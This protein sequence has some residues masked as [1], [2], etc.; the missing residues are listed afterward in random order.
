MLIVAER[1]FVW[2]SVFFTLQMKIFLI[3]SASSLSLMLHVIA[4]SVKAPQ[5]CSYDSQSFCLRFSS[6][7][8]SNVVLGGLLN[9]VSSNVQNS[10]NE[11]AKIFTRGFL[12]AKT[13][14]PLLPS[15]E[16]KI[17]LSFCRL[18]LVSSHWIFSFLRW[19]AFTR[20][21]RI[22]S[23]RSCSS[24]L[25]WLCLCPTRFLWPATE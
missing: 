10:I 6:L 1:S 12:S 16:N 9:A 11:I 14:L 22:V 8:L 21:L 18:Q 4:N 2:V 17:G 25:Y 5:N 20:R 13:L 19:S 3:H 24:S 7:Y 15:A 23:L